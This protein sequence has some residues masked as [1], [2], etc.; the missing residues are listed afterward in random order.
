MR[1]WCTWK[2]DQWKMEWGHDSLMQ[3]LVKDPE[4]VFGLVIITLG[5]TCVG[6]GA[7]LCV[8]V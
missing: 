5:W 1:P 8:H 7:R 3:S 6:G 2:V 4:G